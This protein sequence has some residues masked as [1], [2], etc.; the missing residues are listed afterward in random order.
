MPENYWK[1]LK[2][3]SAYP[4]SAECWLKCLDLKKYPFRDTVSLKY[5]HNWRTNG[6]KSKLASFMWAYLAHF[7]N[8][9]NIGKRSQR[10]KDS[11]AVNNKNIYFR[12]IHYTASYTRKIDYIFVHK[13]NLVLHTCTLLYVVGK[14]GQGSP[15][16]NSANICGLK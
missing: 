4:E 1:T 13:T 2:A 7:L 10:R 9:L 3:I 5:S 11:K 8:I 15:E 14:G 12:H 16:I 6:K